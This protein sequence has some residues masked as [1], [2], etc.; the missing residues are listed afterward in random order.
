M[1]VS[2]F[3]IQLNGNNIETNILG[4]GMAFFSND[5]IHI[6]SSDGNNIRLM[7]LRIEEKG[8]ALA[9]HNK[10]VFSVSFSH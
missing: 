4:G 5:G 9:G 8:I 6:V 1:E 7:S 2:L 3:S 10:A